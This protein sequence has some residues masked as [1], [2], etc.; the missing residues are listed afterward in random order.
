MSHGYNSAI[1]TL[2]NFCGM[3][4]GVD[5]NRCVV[6]VKCMMGNTNARIALDLVYYVCLVY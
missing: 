6:Y 4:G 1:A 2:M 5:T 3:M